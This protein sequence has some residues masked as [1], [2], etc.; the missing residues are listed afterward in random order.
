MTPTGPRTWVVVTGHF[1][2]TSGQGR[3]NL[4]LAEH[5]SGRG[6]RVHLVAGAVEAD[7]A[8]R[9][10]V[11]VHRV[12]YPLG[13]HRLGGELLRRVGRRVAARTTRADPGARVVVNGGN[14]RWDDVVWVH[15]V[16]RAW[17]YDDPSAPLA[18]RLERRVGEWLDQAQERRAL[19]RARLVIAN[20]MRTRRDLVDLLGVPPERVQVV[21]LGTDP[22]RFRPPSPEERAG[23]RARLGVAEGDRLLAF[24][25]AHGP[26][27]KKGFDTVLEAFR[28]VA[29]GEARVSLITAGEGALA[30]WRARVAAL[31]LA[32]RV[33]LLG[34]VGDVTAL[35][36][37]ADLLLAPSRYD[38]YGL[39]VHEA[40]CMGVPAITSVQ[41]GVSEQYPAELRP[42]V[43]ERPE[44]PAALERLLAWC[45]GRLPALRDEV[46]PL[47]ARL[48]ARTWDDMAAEL[49]A[50]VEERP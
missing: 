28:R 20:S 29:A 41:A 1:T 27:P 10:G 50:R 12:W 17:R 40:L 31:G 26:D 44:D 4:A 47:G 9:P 8:R 2:R 48:R 46:A 19:R 33:H 35:L 3:A 38:A 21:A 34:Q 7:L 15:M 18:T 39:N 6:D 22:E 24:V 37:A 23:A 36:A 16:H 49:V 43:L 42:L 30:S 45:L 32:R 13:S 25:G 14:C 5:L 11:V